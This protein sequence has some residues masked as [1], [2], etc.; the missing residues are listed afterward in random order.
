MHKVLVAVLVAHLS[1]PH[2]GGEGWNLTMGVPE[3]AVLSPF[4]FST[5]AEKPHGAKPI[6]SSTTSKILK[7]SFR[8][9]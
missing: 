7:R 8:R 1:W 4:T 9:A 3:S 5:Y 2:Q 6:P